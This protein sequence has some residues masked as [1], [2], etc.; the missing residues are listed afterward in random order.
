MATQIE[1][2]RQ[3]SALRQRLVRQRTTEQQRAVATQQRAVATQQQQN[4]AQKQQIE[5]EVTKLQNQLEASNVAMESYKKTQDRTG[6]RVEQAR[7]QGIYAQLQTLEETKNKLE[8]GG[9]YTDVSQ[10]ISSVKQYGEKVQSAS[11][12]PY[13]PT[14]TTKI[15]EVKPTQPEAVIKSV[16]TPSIFAPK[17]VSPAQKEFFEKFV[18]P[19]VSAVQ[20][21]T[22][23]YEGYGYST[24]QAKTLAKESIAQGGVSFTPSAAL[25][26][27]EKK[28][29]DVP[30]IDT[31]SI[32][33]QRIT[34]TMDVP[35][36]DTT[37]AKY[38]V[39][40]KDYGKRAFSFE[41]GKI[42]P[43]MKEVK[44]SLTVEPYTPP[45]WKLTDPFERTKY[46]VVKKIE[47]KK[48]FA[49]TKTILGVAGI[50]LDIA[51]AYRHPVKTVKGIW[52]MATSAEQRAQQKGIIATTF[53]R[54]P[55][56][57]I[58][59]FLGA[60]LAPKAVKKFKTIRIGE[61]EIKILGVEQKITA[62]KVVTDISFK[63]EQR[64]L[65]T[66]EKIYGAARGVTDIKQLGKGEIQIGKTKTWGVVGKAGTTILSPITYKPK[67]IKARQFQA[68]ETT[69]GQPAKITFERV[70]PKLKVSLEAKGFVQADVGRVTISRGRRFKLT[71]RGFV[72]EKIIKEKFFGLGGGVTLPEGALIFGKYARAFPEVVKGKPKLE[73][74]AYAGFIFGEGKVPKPIIEFEPTGTTTIKP[75]TKPQAVVS[76]MAPLGEVAKAVTITKPT[77]TPTIIKPTTI[78]T[79][80]TRPTAVKIK[81]IEAPLMVG[82]EGLTTLTYEKLGTYERTIGG[83]LPRQPIQRVTPE[84]SV[85]ER[86]TQV[87]KL[88]LKLF[89]REITKQ[90]QPLAL[91]S[92]EMVKQR[93]RQL[94]RQR[95]I[96]KQRQR[97][98][99]IQKII[100]KITTRITTPKFLSRLS[101]LSKAI[102]KAKP[103][104]EVQIRR[105]GKFMKIGKELLPLGKALKLGTER[106]TRT[107]AQTF[108]LIPKGMTVQ[109]DISYKVPTEL[110]TAPKKPTAKIEFVE[111][112]GKTL[113][114]RTGEIPEILKAQKQFNFIGG[115]KKKKKKSLWRI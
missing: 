12:V 6:R 100:P 97:Q 113:K 104:Y 8:A 16:T 69:L 27:I 98:I 9:T 65:L 53:K 51:T 108:R 92:G 103:T 5:Q 24:S 101:R 76:T 60:A 3:G 71:E 7:Q 10:I 107:L 78:T 49:P 93:E 20:A 21:E 89:E 50:G 11:Y 23:R 59:Y 46:E 54:E 39:D 77:P 38:F 99:Q 88:D 111:R 62:K 43:T 57:A 102:S 74:T 81:P 41:T 15:V 109:T 75:V 85:R 52:G 18:T 63:I 115:T 31:R 110:F 80:T 106:T 86:I 84:I 32:T 56:Y 35:K 68:F 42:L 28:Q 13:K 96:I 112:R 17:Y 70:T 55:E 90:K 95:Q 4:I 82:G 66:K 34:R 87:P 44:E 25:K 40:T 29:F 67:L 79:V 58:G 105:R 30:K 47:S 83:Q 33:P 61:P 1:L 94:L 19:K 36:V 114:K 37:Y 64:K 73:K 91:V 45:K 72:P 26:V 22:K 48:T 14:T 2:R